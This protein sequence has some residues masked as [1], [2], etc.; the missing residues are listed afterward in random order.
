MNSKW[1]RK[2]AIE[3]RPA[4]EAKASIGGSVKLV[5]KDGKRQIEGEFGIDECKGIKA[6]LKFKN[7]VSAVYTDLKGDKKPL[8]KP[9][10][11][12]FEKELWDGCL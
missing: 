8:W 4:F 6:G 3:E 7:E 1:E 2:F 9:K 10:P 5:E 11:L 12:E